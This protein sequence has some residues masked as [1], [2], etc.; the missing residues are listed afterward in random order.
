MPGMIPLLRSGKLHN[1][2]RLSRRTPFIRP[3]TALRKRRHPHRTPWRVDTALVLPTFAMLPTLPAST[4]ED[5]RDPVQEEIRHRDAEEIR[6][7][8]E[9]VALDTPF[10][11]ENF[12]NPRGPVAG[13]FGKV[14]RDHV[15]GLEQVANILDE[16]QVC[17]H[18]PAHVPSQGEANIAQV[19]RSGRGMYSKVCRSV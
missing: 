13:K 15:P 18:K 14:F 19:A 8:I 9:V 3:I 7:D 2:H 17:F 5:R 11:G 6:N 12:G 16:D 4:F 1:A 10:A